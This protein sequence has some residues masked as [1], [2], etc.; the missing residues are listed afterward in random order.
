MEPRS[1][2][3]RRLLPLIA[4]R[5]N[6]HGGRSLMTCQ[7]RCGNQCDHA[8]ANTSDNPCF[9]DVAS[10][11]MSRRG[12]LTAG[13]AAGLV[14]STG[15]LGAATAAPASSGGAAVA[16]RIKAPGAIPTLDL[17]YAPVPPNTL[18]TVVVPNG[19]EWGVVIRWGDPVERHAPAF[20]FENQSATAQATQ[21][22]Y[23]CDFV[24][25][26]PLPGNDR[27]LL[28]V[29]HE[30]TDEELMFSGYTGGATATEEQIK[31]AMAAHGMSVVEIERVGATGRWVR[32]KLSRYNRRIHTSTRMELT[33][34]AAGSALLRS[35]RDETGRVAYGTLNNCAGGVTPWGT[36][37]SGEENF[38]QYFVNGAETPA[39]YQDSFSRYGVPSGT[40]GRRWDRVDERFDLGR[41]PQE[42]YRHGWIVELDPFDPDFVPK[43]RT[44]LGRLKHEGATVSLAADGRVVAYMGDDER[45]DYIYKF[46]S[47][48]P[49]RPE[50]SR[51]AR[52]HNLTLLDEGTLYV[53]RFNG[54]SP[55]G[56]IDGTGT[57]PA[58]GEFDGT[59][60]WI[61]LVVGDE[62]LVPGMPVDQALINTRLAADIVGATKMD[63]P[64]DIE[65]NP[66]NGRIY[67]AL[68]NNSARTAATV[69]EANPLARSIVAGGV[70]A[71]GNRNGHVLEIEEHGNDVAA[72]AFAWRVFLVC[73]DPAAAETY[74][75]GFPKED[76]S[77]IS[78]PD[79][80]AFDAGGNLWISTDGNALGSNDGLFSVPVEGPDRGRVKQFM[81]V[82][83]GAETCGP[84]I[85]G[86][87]T[88]VFVAVQHPGEVSGASVENPASTWPNGRF[89]Q[90]SVVVAWKRDR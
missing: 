39:E 90:P 70:Q 65:R 15:G 28:V 34:P 41:E 24:A 26:L 38:H 42:A 58:D 40:G 43:K 77:P 14:L 69:D 23:N 86:D 46:V 5:Q 73:G 2:T 68:T 44:A 80:V 29:N 62:S 84:T 85:L 22:G 18:D 32:S 72:S 81:T 4:T 64:E 19:Y 35:S 12:L 33:G 11:A 17:G 88:S 45:F 75:G 54:D 82:P 27:A 83:I 7:Y 79:N 78:C 61:P 36:V 16:G 47:S 67:A 30:Y 89:P 63:R 51:A 74:F 3:R 71:S 60:E 48:K 8:V 49:M 13:A 1:E 9:A 87:G 20:D 31:I 25:V 66:V 6:R 21:F 56:E 10:M 55:P 37:L 52:E 76:V 57:L 53:A 59:G 50:D